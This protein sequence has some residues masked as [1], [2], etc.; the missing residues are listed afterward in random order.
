MC[1]VQTGNCLTSSFQRNRNLSVDKA[2]CISFFCLYSEMAEAKISVARDQFSCSVCLDLLKDPVTIPCGHSYCMSCITDYWNQDDQTRVY[3]CPQ[4]RQ[5]F[6]QRPALGKNTML[7]EVVEKLKKTKEVQTA[8]TA[9]SYAGPGDVGCDFCTGRKRKAVKSCLMCLESYCQNHFKCH[10]ESPLKK[11]HK[12]TDATGQL[13][14][15]ICPQHDRLLEVF[16]RTDQRCICLMCVM[17]EHKNHD[18][19]PAEAERTEKQKKVGEIQGKF[20]QRVQE[21]QKELQELREAVETHKRSAQA[22]VEVSERIFTELIRSIERSRSE[23]TQMIRDQ[24]KAAVSRAEG[25]LKRLEQE[26][27]D[28]SRREVE[29]EQFSH[30]DNHIHFLQSFQSL[31]EHL[32]S[33]D[34]SSVT[35]S[36]VLSYKDVRKPVSQLKEKLEKFCKEEMKKISGRVRNINIISSNEPKTMEE[37]LQY[38]HQLSLDPNTVNKHVHLSE[39]NTVATYTDTVEAYPDHPDRF[40]VW[41]QVLCRESVC[42][43]CYWEVESSEGMGIS[44]SYKSIR[45]KGKTKECIFGFNDQSWRLSC[46]ASSYSFSHNSKTVQLPVISSSSR[47]G[48][49][50]DHRAG[51]LSFYSVSDT[52]TLIHRVQTT[53]TQ[54][55]YLGFWLYNQQ[56]NCVI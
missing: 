38:S 25:L 5:T 2:L 54:P 14:E 18:T 30:T 29:L 17:D 21:R 4:C 49:Y 37:F 7:A 15:M 6:T 40:D 13:Q 16:C 48:V 31:S 50:V 35:V 44:V 45:R 41:P 9:L 39:D 24:E 53:F 10:E 47:I 32:E 27:D 3:S 8:R 33:T 22:A 52:M 26:I 36:S 55:L 23:V 28:L 11:R 20:Q 46:S 12:V 43:H 56:Q 1:Y 19:V 51:I 34:V 42:G